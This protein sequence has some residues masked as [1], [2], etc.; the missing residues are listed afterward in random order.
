MSNFKPNQNQGNRQQDQR[1]YNQDKSTGFNKDKDP[2]RQGS[3]TPSNP[4]H[5]NKK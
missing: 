3:Y 1:T 2:S 5:T 4:S